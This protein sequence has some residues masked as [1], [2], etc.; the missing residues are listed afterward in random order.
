MLEQPST[1][2]RT[3][4]FTLMELMVTMAIAAS[5]LGLGAKLF[6]ARGKRTAAEKPRSRVSAMVD[7]VRDASSRFHSMV[8]VAP[9]ERAVRAMAQEARQK[10]HFDPRSVE[11]AEPQYAKAIEGRNCDWMGNNF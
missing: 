7:K 1:R 11:G 10:L 9:E 3:S 2:R 6:T 8:S 5:L 4:G